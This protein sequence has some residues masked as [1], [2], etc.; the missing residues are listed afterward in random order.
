M[1][2]CGSGVD[3]VMPLK[4]FSVGSSS[5]VFTTG[6]GAVTASSVKQYRNKTCKGQ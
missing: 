4:A 6:L 2:E 1:V 3:D 5:S